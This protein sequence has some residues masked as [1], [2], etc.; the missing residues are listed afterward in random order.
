MSAKAWTVADHALLRSMADEGHSSHTIAKAL[1]RSRS[2]VCGMAR[3]QGL[4]LIGPDSETRKEKRGG[5]TQAR[6][7]MLAAHVAAG[8]TAEEIGTRLRVSRT[9][10]IA[11]CRRYGI[12]MQRGRKRVRPAPPERE[13]AAV[14]R[15]SWTPER[16]DQL[17]A[18]V[19]DG[20]TSSQIADRMGAS[21]KSVAGACRRYGIA[22]ECGRKRIWSEERTA[23]LRA[24]A[25]AG[26]PTGEAAKR[27]GVS[28]GALCGAARKVGVSFKP[29]PEADGRHGGYRPH[30]VWTEERLAIVREVA[31]SGGTAAQAADRLGVP[32][33]ALKSA[34]RKHG[35][36]FDSLAAKQATIW[37]G[38]EDR[39]R[40]LVAAGF[41]RARIARELGVS[42]SSVRT[43]CLALRIGA[44]RETRV[45]KAGAAPAPAG[46]VTLAVVRS[47]GAASPVCEAAEPRALS[48]VIPLP[49]PR[50]TG[51]AGPLPFLDAVN[52]RCRMPLWSDA[53]H[54][55]LE[56]KFVCGAPVASLKES[57]CPACRA[58]AWT[59]A[60]NPNRVAIKREI[61]RRA[62]SW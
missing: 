18:L 37:D 59:K 54:E 50:P 7:E 23:I 17:R 57:Y 33:G 6:T 41:T 28:V 21:R 11:A 49:T 58:T 60:R 61:E 36:T 2:A 19:A 48:N 13:K 8:L 16:V 31:A 26:V 39:L 14:A 32:A 4:R 47:L 42:E 46:Q 56:D 45:Q 30:R 44:V 40:E 3:R 43:R 24:L 51:E 15:P 22:V 52:G 27:L 55:P 20:L 29:E 25:A 12:E 5:W 62:Q 35:I 1:G 34:A 53:G 9:S 38:K 10:V